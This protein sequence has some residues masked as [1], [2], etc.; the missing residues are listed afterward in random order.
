MLNFFDRI[1]DNLWRLAFH[2]IASTIIVFGLLLSLVTSISVFLYLYPIFEGSPNLCFGAAF[3]ALAAS[4]F[5]IMLFANRGIHV[6]KLLISLSIQ[7]VSLVILFAG[8]YRGFG[9]VGNGEVLN[10]IEAGTALY[11]SLVTWTTL[12]YG[13]YAPRAEI[14]LIAA[15]QAVAGYVFLGMIV[16]MLAAIMSE[17]RKD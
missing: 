1:L 4:G 10:N 14:Q 13:D 6:A 12:G 7:A 9:L 11:F 8:I 16:A 3:T 15:F 17:R 5:S 2:S